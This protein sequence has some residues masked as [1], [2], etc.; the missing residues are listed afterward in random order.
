M[1]TSDLSPVSNTNRS[2]G[3]TIANNCTIS[4]PSFKTTFLQVRGPG[5]ESPMV[6]FFVLVPSVT[7][8]PPG[9]TASALPAHASGSKDI[10]I[11]DFKWCPQAEVFLILFQR[12]LFSYEPKTKNFVQIH[13]ARHKDYPYGS[14]ELLDGCNLSFFRSDFGV[15]RVCVTRRSTFLT[16]SSASASNCGN[17]R[18]IMG[19]H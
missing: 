7:P 5:H 1:V 18:T 3:S 13:I 11:V 4:T 12:H 19:I 9:T 6:Q 16:A 2:S 8:N 17:I 14:H 15:F 10:D